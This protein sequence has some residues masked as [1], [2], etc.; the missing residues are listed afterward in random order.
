MKKLLP[1]VALLAATVACQ[2][3][4]A[5]T[6]AANAAADST[7]TVADTLHYEGT[8]PAADGPGIRYTIALSG[9]SVLN[10]ALT[11][12]Y[13]E[14]ENGKDQT[15]HYQGVGELIVGKGIKLPLG[16]NDT[17]YFKEVN[18]STLRMVN[19]DFEEAEGK[20]LSYDLKRK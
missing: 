19:S 5:S 1:L 2:Q 17:L 13:L 15:R 16:A 7:Q 14:A 18:D 4:P 3:K 6:D 9:D 12:T 10:F 20:D 11:Q 8:V